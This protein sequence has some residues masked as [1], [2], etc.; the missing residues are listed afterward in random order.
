[1]LAASERFLIMVCIQS[2]RI[3]LVFARKNAKKEQKKKTTNLIYRIIQLLRVP[4]LMTR[5]ET[6]LW[7]LQFPSILAEITQDVEAVTNACNEVKG[8]D[9]LAQMLKVILHLGSI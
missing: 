7:K 2:M 6:F 4:R 5:L 3:Y 9:K 1:M 8:S